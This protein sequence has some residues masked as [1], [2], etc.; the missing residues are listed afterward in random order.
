MRLLKIL[1]KFPLQA[2]EKRT[3][4]NLILFSLFLIP[5]LGQ[6]QVKTGGGSVFDP[7]KNPEYG[8]GGGVADADEGLVLTGEYVAQLRKRELEC[9]SKKRE[10]IKSKDFMKVYM[11]VSM[12][13]S[14][15]TDKTKKPEAECNFANEFLSCI[16]NEKT[17]EIYK[18]MSSN[19]KVIN[20]LKNKYNI[21]EKQAQK[22]IKFFEKFEVE[23]K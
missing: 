18:K 16:N 1:V 4:K 20:H 6:T 10:L 17:Q 14:L 8:G 15:F 5:L 13:S 3:M 2:G 23:G 7:T 21:D 9:G 19:P 11:S 12:Y 22:M